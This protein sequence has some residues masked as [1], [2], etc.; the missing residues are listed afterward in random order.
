MRTSLLLIVAMFATMLLGCGSVNDKHRTPARLDRH[1]PMMTS[2]YMQKRSGT[3][4]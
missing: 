1:D 2:R 4:H 3:G